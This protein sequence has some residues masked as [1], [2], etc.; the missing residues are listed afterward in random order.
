LKVFERPVLL[1][2]AGIRVDDGEVLSRGWWDF[3][4]RRGFGERLR[5]EEGEGQV[6][7][8]VTELGARGAV[9]GVDFVEVFEQR[10][11]CGRDSYQ[12]DTCVGDGSC[13]IG[14]ADQGEGHARSPDFGV[15][16]SCGFERR[17]G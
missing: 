1:W 3:D 14:E 12:I 11:F 4:A 8:G 6:R 2:A 17:E 13:P 5:R 15:F 16:S 9:P 10:A 7:D